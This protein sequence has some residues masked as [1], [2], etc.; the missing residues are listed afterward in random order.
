[1]GDD[2]TYD[3]PWRHAEDPQSW[4]IARPEH[5]WQ[6]LTGRDLV[7]PSLVDERWIEDHQP[8]MIL[9]RDATSAHVIWQD[10]TEEDFPL[11]YLICVGRAEG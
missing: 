6:Q 10:F 3:F 2:N 1:M 11:A 5:E 9:E 8:G 4:F 7:K